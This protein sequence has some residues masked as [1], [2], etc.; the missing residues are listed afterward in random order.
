[1]GQF[2]GSDSCIENILVGMFNGLCDKSWQ[3]T[4]QEF[5]KGNIGCFYLNG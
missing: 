2:W 3:N 1:M 5:L 4:I